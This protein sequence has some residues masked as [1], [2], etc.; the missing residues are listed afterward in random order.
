MG[1]AIRC[2]HYKGTYMRV[3]FMSGIVSDGQFPAVCIRDD[4]APIQS[5]R[6]ER[7][8]QGQSPANAGIDRPLDY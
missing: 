8:E 7:L 4:G 1:K 6:V 2:Q 3:W 5:A